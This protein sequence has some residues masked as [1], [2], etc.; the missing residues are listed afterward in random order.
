[1]MGWIETISDKQFL[2][3]GMI[4]HPPFD[5]TGVSGTM[6]NEL[7]EERN[8]KQW[9]RLSFSSIYYIITQLEKMKLIKAKETISNTKAQS[10]VGAPQKLFIV[11]STGQRIL[12]STVI[13]YFHKMDLNYQE[14]NLALAAAFVFDDEEF[15]D[16]IK[17]YKKRIDERIEVVRGR[18]KEDSKYEQEGDL[19]IHVWA[20]FN[21]SFNSLSA[22]NIFLKELIDKIEEKLNSN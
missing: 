17:N 12:K 9:S 7:I 16:T 22:K 4:A 8:V 13:H 1:M 6:L 3:L 15:L 11:T 18:F 20:L 19:P 10:E 2:V 14:M 5:I 21:Y